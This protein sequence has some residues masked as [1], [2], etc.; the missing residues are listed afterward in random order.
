MKDFIWI[1]GLGILGFFGYEYFKNSQMSVMAA[2]PTSTV[3]TPQVS[4]GATILTTGGNGKL[5]VHPNLTQA[6][7][8]N[9]INITKTNGNGFSGP[10]FDSNGNQLATAYEWQ[11]AYGMATGDGFDY[12][13]AFAYPTQLITFSNWIQVVQ[14]AYSGVFPQV[15]GNPGL[16]TI[17]RRQAWNNSQFSKYDLIS[18][19]FQR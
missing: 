1:A 19:G 12:S 6:D 5:S 7:I 2:I 17:G 3:T 15:L 11:V 8:N 4:T 16:G 14:Q 10:N 9:I 13:Q 18:A